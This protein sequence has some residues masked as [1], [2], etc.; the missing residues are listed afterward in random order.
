MDC[1]TTGGVTLHR[2]HPHCIWQQVELL[3]RAP[4]RHGHAQ[5]LDLFFERIYLTHKYSMKIQNAE[6]QFRKQQNRQCHINSFSVGETT[7]AWKEHG[8]EQGWA[9]VVRIKPLRCMQ[10]SSNTFGRLSVLIY[11]L[12]SSNLKP[13]RQGLLSV[14]HVRSA[15]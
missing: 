11:Y 13:M 4:P 7:S 6:V 2:L 8:Q 5:R 15:R 12:F 3:R 1:W 10:S 9:P 14:V